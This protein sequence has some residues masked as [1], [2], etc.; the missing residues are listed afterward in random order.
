[1]I[2]PTDGQPVPHPG[3]PSPDGKVS[4]MIRFLV[5]HETY[6]VAQ[7]ANLRCW[8]GHKKMMG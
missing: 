4:G 3:P 5:Y 7:A 8:L 2:D 6:H 1:M